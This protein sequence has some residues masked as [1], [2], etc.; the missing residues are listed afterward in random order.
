MERTRNAQ[1]K[2]QRIEE[3][4]DKQLEDLRIIQDENKETW[5]IVKN[6]KGE[7]DQ[8][9]QIEFTKSGYDLVYMSFRPFEP[10]FVIRASRSEDGINRVLDKTKTIYDATEDEIMELVIQILR[11]N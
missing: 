7:T 6:T 5:D 11:A 9:A 2:R 1:D 8:V 3:Q 10:T 4:T